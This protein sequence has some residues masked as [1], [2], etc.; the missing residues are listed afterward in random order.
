LSIPIEDTEAGMGE[1]LT[2]Y[3]GEYLRN[4][5]ASWHLAL[6]G[7][8]L[9]LWIFPMWRIIGKAGYPPAL[10]LLAVF[11]AVGLILLW[12]LAFARWPAERDRPSAAMEPVAW[13]RGGLRRR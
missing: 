10:S 12:W 3:A 11:P 6:L 4:Y 13:D 2:E 8:L 1:Y 9:F 7:L 5:Y